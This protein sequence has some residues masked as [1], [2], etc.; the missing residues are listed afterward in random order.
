MNKYKVGDTVYIQT[1]Q[2]VNDQEKDSDGDIHPPADPNFHNAVFSSGM[3]VFA[4]HQ[5][6]IINIRQNGYAL[7]VDGG[8]YTWEDWMFQNIPPP[9]KYLVLCDYSEGVND[10]AVERQKQQKY[11]DDKWVNDEIITA[12]IYYLQAVRDKSIA[13]PPD[14][15]WGIAKWKPFDSPLSLLGKAGALIAAE[16]D[17]RKKNATLVVES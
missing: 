12:A 13:H 2:W 7:D 11:A 17:R 1:K 10:L 14:W 6:I 8:D 5:A 3:F 9:S 15:T 16:I 4:G